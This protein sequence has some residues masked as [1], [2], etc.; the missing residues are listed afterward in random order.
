MA[1]S[2]LAVLVKVRWCRLVGHSEVDLDD[3]FCFFFLESLGCSMSFQRSLSLAFMVAMALPCN[4]AFGCK[5]WTNLH[6]L[7]MLFPIFY[8]SHYS[9]LQRIL[10]SNV[11]CFK[12]FIVDVEVIQAVSIIFENFSSGVSNQEQ[13][14]MNQVNI[15]QTWSDLRHHTFFKDNHCDAIRLRNTFSSFPSPSGCF[16]LPSDKTLVSTALMV[17]S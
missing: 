4:L 13:S 12:T 9:R 15:Y 3:L 10:G 11:A 16:Q 7:Q 17:F 1:C 14:L 5:T 2:S 8:V 6:F